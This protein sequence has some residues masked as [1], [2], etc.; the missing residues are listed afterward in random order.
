MVDARRRADYRRSDDDE[1][2][3]QDPAAQRGRDAHPRGIPSTDR[4][5]HPEL[6]GRNGDADKGC[7]HDDLQSLA[8]GGGPGEALL[9]GGSSRRRGN[10]DCAPGPGDQ[11][12]GKLGK[13]V[14]GQG[15]ED[16][17]RNGRGNRPSP[18]EGQVFAQ[19]EEGN[20]R[21]AG[22]LGDEGSGGG[23]DREQ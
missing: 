20:R 23:G 2:G 8:A 9:D 10:Q 6:G 21:C 17:H 5:R 16:H 7:E 3:D 1:A 14:R 11:S 4:Q 12:G 15:Q 18:G 19:E 13:A 22:G